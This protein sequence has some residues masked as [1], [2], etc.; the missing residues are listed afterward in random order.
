MMLVWCELRMH[1]TAEGDYHCDVAIDGIWS[2]LSQAAR[3]LSDKL[4]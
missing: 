4:G 1:E 2:L 3:L